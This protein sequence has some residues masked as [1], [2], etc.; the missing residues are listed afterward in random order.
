MFK[1][2]ED[3]TKKIEAISGIQG[4]FFRFHND[5]IQY[6]F[7]F[8]DFNIFNEMSEILPCGWSMELIREH[9]LGVI[10]FYPTI[11]QIEEE[12]EKRMFP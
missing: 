5:A 3:L 4:V 1:E 11:Q 9:D 6:V 10:S 2:F 12:I 7:S 8:T